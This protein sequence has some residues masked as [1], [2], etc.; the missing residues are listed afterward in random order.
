MLPVE[1]V[2][3]AAVLDADEADLDAAVLVVFA[4]V[5]AP[6]QDDALGPE[7]VNATRL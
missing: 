5:V 3:F 7:L 1:P 6:T 2:E 4:F